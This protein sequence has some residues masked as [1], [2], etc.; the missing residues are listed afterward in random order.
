MMKKSSKPFPRE[1]SPTPFV[2]FSLLLSCGNSVLTQPSLRTE[3]GTVLPNPVKLKG[4]KLSWHPKK[5][6][7]YQSLKHSISTLI[8]CPGFL[9]KTKLWRSRQVP[10]NVMCDVYDGRN[11]QEFQTVNGKP[12]LAEACNFALLQGCDWF[13]PFKHVSDSVGAIYMV[14]LNL[15]REERYKPENIIL[16]GIIPGPAEPKETINTYLYPFVDE[17]LQFWDGVEINNS[18]V[19]PTTIKVRLAVLCVSCD[20]P[21]TRKIC[22][23]A[24]HSACRGCSK[25][26]SKFPSGV[27]E[28]KLDY[29]D[30]NRGSWVPRTKSSHQYRATLVQNAKTMCAQKVLTS[31][32]GLRYSVFLLLPYFNVVRMYVVDPMHNLLL[33]TSKHVMQ[34]WTEKKLIAKQEFSHIQQVV[35]TIIVPKQVGRIP[36]KIGSSFSGFSADQWKNWTTIFSPVALKG[37]IPSSHLNCWLMYIR[38]CTL[39]CARSIRL[40]S[41]ETVDSY[42]VNCCRLFTSLNGGKYCNINLHLHLHLKECVL[43]NGPLYGW[44]CF[45]FERYNGML[46]NYYTSNRHIE[47][48]IMRKFLRH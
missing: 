3:C 13:Q 27:F 8:N 17:L 34:V 46:G 48:Q 5:V 21:A 12:F 11:W 44:W 32:Y 47:P 23:F 26:F 40:S 14:I 36:T 19:F 22:G 2:S 18:S 41:V 45:A 24:S 33:G 16:V 10:D 1:E 43:D 28:N 37:I 15:P 39:L 31:L 30:F 20:I 9:E 25:C 6:Y 4:N 7:C 38:A 42:L 29:S 35:S